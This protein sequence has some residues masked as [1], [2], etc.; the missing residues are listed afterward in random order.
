[1]VGPA[2]RREA[3]SHLQRELELSQRRACQVVGQPRATQRHVPEP[4]A[5]EEPLRTLASGCR[6]SGGRKG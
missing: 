4:D 2:R 1:M 3:V 6:D 5:G